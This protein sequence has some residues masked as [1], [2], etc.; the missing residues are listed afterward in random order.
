MISFGFGITRYERTEERRSFHIEQAR[1]HHARRLSSMQSSFP[2]APVEEA[3]A[4]NRKFIPRKECAASFCVPTTSMGGR[5]GIAVTG[6]SAR[7]RDLFRAAS[8]Q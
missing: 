7:E 6:R 8:T 4:L 3:D 2:A 1:E 5:G